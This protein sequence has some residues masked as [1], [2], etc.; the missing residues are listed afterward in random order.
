MELFS[1]IEDLSGAR[2]QP[3]GGMQGESGEILSQSKTSVPATVMRA[4]FHV[5]GS[6]VYEE[7]GSF[8]LPLPSPNSAAICFGAPRAIAHMHGPYGSLS[9]PRVSA[10]QHKSGP[11]K[12][13]EQQSCI[14]HLWP[15][16]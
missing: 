13:F 16:R 6:V 7:S 3:I 10:V 2:P 15:T 1:I 14:F 5:D 4:E 8:S 11:N 12:L 9:A